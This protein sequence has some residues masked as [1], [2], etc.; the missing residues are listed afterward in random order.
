MLFYLQVDHFDNL[1]KQFGIEV[2]EEGVAQLAYFI[3]SLLPE[4][5]SFGRIREEAFALIIASSD[6]EKGLALANRIVKEVSSHIFNTSSNSFTCT[7]SIGLTLIG[8]VTGSADEGLSTCQKA[9]AELQTPD[10]SGKSGNGAKLHETV[11]DLSNGENISDSDIQRIGRQL[12]KKNLVSVAFQP[13]VSLHGLEDEFYE[14]LMRIQPEGFAAGEIP[15]DFIA[16][17]FKTDIGCELDK[18]VIESALEKLRDK[19]A[20]APHTRLFIHLSQATIADEKFIPWLQKTLERFRL[21]PADLVFQMREMDISRQLGKAANMLERLRNFGA[22]TG[23]THYGLAINPLTI[24]HKIA[25]DYVKVDGVL[26][27]KAQ[28][29]KNALTNLK[30]ILTELKGEKLKVIVPFIESATIIPTL[31][32]GGVDFLQGHYIQQPT[33]DMNFDFSQE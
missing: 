20:L 15:A 23:L 30:G 4:K 9:V 7:L 2:V 18:L 28:K 16:K 33:A 6:T 21:A 29:D 8:E 5:V 25:V 22:G 11:F 19:K 3:D 12:I 24:F 14:V 1:Q 13:V 32:Q 27:D 26:S 31:W 10:A 17:V